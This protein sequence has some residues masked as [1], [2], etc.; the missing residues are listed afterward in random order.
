MTIASSYRSSWVGISSDSLLS[1]VVADR[2]VFLHLD[3]KKV[4]QQGF[5]PVLPLPRLC[6]T[7][8]CGARS[9]MYYLRSQP[10]MIHLRTLDY[11]QDGSDDTTG[12]RTIRKLRS[13]GAN[14]PSHSLRPTARSLSNSAIWRSSRIAKSS[15]GRNHVSEMPVVQVEPTAFVNTCRHMVTNRDGSLRPMA[16]TADPAA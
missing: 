11:D 5:V 7:G 2:R 9:D 15:I 16:T 10:K 14:R 3:A 8:G 6:I 12:L 1:K 4:P 13:V